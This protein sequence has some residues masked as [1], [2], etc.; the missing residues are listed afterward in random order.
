ME[1]QAN[2]AT[3]ADC[4]TNMTTVAITAYL[5]LYL[6]SASHNILKSHALNA[7]PIWSQ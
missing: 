6:D 3:S 2:T 7:G 4:Y 1:R 5:L